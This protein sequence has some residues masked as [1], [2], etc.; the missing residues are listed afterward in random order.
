MSNHEGDRTCGR[1]DLASQV[2]EKGAE[3]LAGVEDPQIDPVEDIDLEFV[4][5]CFESNERG[6][7]LL[8][9]SMLRD[10]YLFIP[11]PPNKRGDRGVWYF[12]NGTIW[13]LDEYDIIVDE[14]EKV[15][16]A[17]ERC[18]DQLIEDK[19]KRLEELEKERAE[20]IALIKESFDTDK[21]TAKID[22]IRKKPLDVPKWLLRKIRDYEKRAFNL[23]SKNKINTVVHLAPRL[24]P[25]IAIT[26]N[27]LDQQEMLFPVGNGVID[28]T[29]GVLVD[30][31]PSD[32]MTRRS[33]VE[34]DDA[35][36]YGEWEEIL[37][38]ICIHPDLDGS[39][40]LPKFLQVYLGYCMTA[41]VKEEK[42][43]VLIG[44][45]RNGKGTILE[46]VSKVF[47][48]FFHQASRALFVEQRFEPPPSAA[49]EHLWAL[50]AKRLVISSETN[51]KHRVDDGRLKELTGGNAINFRRN[52]GSEE[53]F[54]PTF[55]F[56]LDTNNVLGGLTKSFS[57]RERLVIIDFPWRYVDDPERA[58]RKEPSLRGRFKKKDN[59]LKNRLK[60]PEMQSKIL[61][62]LV[63]GCLEWQRLGELQVP[64]ICDDYKM[65]IEKT[66]NHIGRF[67][68]EM[69]VV[70]N[71]DRQTR[72]AFSDLYEKVFLW[73]WEENMDS[74]AGKKPHK[75]TLSKYL[76]EVGYEDSK[77]GGKLFFFDIDV[78]N[79]VKLEN[80][81]MA[82]LTGYVPG[83]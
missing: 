11:P 58:A 14:V 27:L 81:E 56:I 25:S 16:R 40:E 70:T 63:D 52:F 42:I 53:V 19:N 21:A 43:L 45:G 28:L 83:K 26:P 5:E 34:Y 65:V 76:R 23:R 50:M 82:N 9:A 6:D 33:E 39:D 7:A 68:E 79:E 8:L 61:K 62:W 41:S 73:W 46:P 54:R 3:V 13:Q 15:A 49:S 37:K 59:N 48:S 18:A 71:E 78:K 35:V 17:Y 20:E 10:R 1:S 12:W 22:R 47:G 44:V 32:L 31:L 55:K 24:D 80:P 74:S 30:G 2:A 57:L 64:R 77:V 75:N 72:M 29:K 67:V 51:A 4:R 69:L 66:E 36:D 38:D 60:T